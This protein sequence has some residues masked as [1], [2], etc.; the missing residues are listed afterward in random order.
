MSWTE[1]DV[2]AEILDSASAPALEQVVARALARAA[3][4]GLPDGLATQLRALLARIAGVLVP[5]AG[6]PTG[7]STAD[8]SRVIAA[9]AG[10]VLGIELEGLSAEDIEL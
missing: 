7:L 5:V 9:R 2:A 10:R 1:Q 3:P 8:T 4:G 6:R